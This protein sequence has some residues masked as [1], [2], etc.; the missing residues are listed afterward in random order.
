[1]AFIAN[2]AFLR[3]MHELDAGSKT[4]G[5]KH[6]ASIPVKKNGQAEHAGDYEKRS[7]CDIYNAE[8]AGWCQGRVQS[9]VKLDK[10][11]R[12]WTE[13]KKARSSFLLLMTQ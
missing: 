12:R 3:I 6:E 4:Q 5:S 9:T 11:I 2:N 1:M 7:Q 13:V 8:D 10:I